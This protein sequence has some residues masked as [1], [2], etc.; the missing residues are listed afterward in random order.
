MAAIY[1]ALVLAGSIESRSKG[2]SGTEFLSGNP[3]IY[4]YKFQSHPDQILK[5]WFMSLAADPAHQLPAFTYVVFRV[6]GFR[7]KLFDGLPFRRSLSE[8]EYDDDAYL[9]T[10]L[11]IVQGSSAHL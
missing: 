5:A 6:D 1:R 8:E 3:I 2:L 4:N 7:H 11:H 10:R 9:E